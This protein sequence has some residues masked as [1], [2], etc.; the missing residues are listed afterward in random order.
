MAS[1]QPL[2]GMLRMGSIPTIGPFLLP[3]VLPSLRQTYGN[4]KLY[5]VED[6]TDR[7]IESLH[8][9]QL[10]VVLLALPYDCGP[11]ETVILFEDPFVGALPHAHPLPRKAVSSRSGYDVSI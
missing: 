2:T 4:L 1:R 8:R 11:V 10:D 3:R 9:G 6:L 7:L 5:L